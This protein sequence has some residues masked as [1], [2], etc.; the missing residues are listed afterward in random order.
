MKQRPS[1]HVCPT[2]GKCFIGSNSIYRFVQKLFGWNRYK[3]KRIVFQIN[4]PMLILL[5]LYFLKLSN[6]IRIKWFTYR[7]TTL[8]V[9]KFF[10]KSI[11]NRN[12]LYKLHYLLLIFISSIHWRRVNWE[13][14]VQF[15]FVLKFSLM[16][17]KG[18]RHISDLYKS[19]N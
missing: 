1:R 17:N 8:E 14:I 13:L 12:I 3:L 7:I 15:L 5:Y 11:V 2:K 18:E 4:Q 19:M 10:K 6:F 9:Y 16:Y